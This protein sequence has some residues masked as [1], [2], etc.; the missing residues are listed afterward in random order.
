VTLGG[1]RPSAMDG[2]GPAYL[3]RLTGWLPAPVV[4][5]TD[6]PPSAGEI[7]GPAGLGAA[8]PWMQADLSP[9]GS[10]GPSATEV[11]AVS[12]SGAITLTEYTLPGGSA[13]GLLRGR[14]QV[15]LEVWDGSALTG[16][17]FTL[18]G[19]VIL[20]LYPDGWPETAPSSTA[21]PSPATSSMR[22]SGS[23]NP[24]WVWSPGRR[25]STH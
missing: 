15:E 18:G 4:G 17:T 9:V 16:V 24:A 10:G 1:L 19:D 13:R 25:T 14:Y 12:R 5:E 11:Q 23:T 2:S 22:R 8:V 7:L 20:P 21:T 6:L 3:V